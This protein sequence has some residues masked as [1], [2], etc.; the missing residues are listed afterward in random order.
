[1]GNG[2]LDFIVSICASLVI[3][4]LA[5]LISRRIIILKKILAF[6]GTNSLLILCLHT[7]D[8]GALPTQ[9]LLQRAAAFI[10]LSMNEIVFTSILFC[11]RIIYVT[12]GILIITRVRDRWKGMIKQTR[13]G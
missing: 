4:M 13:L 3:M 8:L 10:G 7:I 2:W 12:V 11:V 9:W 6:Y 5:S 1:M